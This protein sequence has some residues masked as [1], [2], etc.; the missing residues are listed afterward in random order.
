MA[1]TSVKEIYLIGLPL[2]AKTSN[3]HGQSS[4]DCKNLWHRFEE[5]NYA[6]L[7]THKLSN[8][9]Y[10]VYHQYEGDSNKPFSYFIGCRVEKGGAIPEGLTYL[11]IP[12]GTYEK[13]TVQGKMPD[14]VTKAW[15]EIWGADYDRAYNTDFEVYDERSRDWSHAEVDVYVSIH[16]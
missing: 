10:G 15:K 7:I 6:S 3:A 4:I 9:I 8:E 1:R 11:T 16:E 2:A 12:A 14:C 5:G 13:I